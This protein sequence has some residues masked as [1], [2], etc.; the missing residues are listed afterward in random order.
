MNLHCVS[1]RTLTVQIAG[2]NGS[3]LLLSRWQLCS[4][5]FS[6]QVVGVTGVSNVPSLECY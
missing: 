5:K 4:S 1:H 2:S 3:V 6:Q